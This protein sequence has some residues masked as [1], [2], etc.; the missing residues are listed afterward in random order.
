VASGGKQLLNVGDGRR[1]TLR[2]SPFFF[3]SIGTAE[4]VAENLGKADSSR[5]G[6]SPLDHD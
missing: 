6:A 2:V 4:Q 5:L 1:T 3:D